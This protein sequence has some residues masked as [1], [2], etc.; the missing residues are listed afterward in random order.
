VVWVI[1][2]TSF[3]L[4]V[5]VILLGPGVTGVREHACQDRID[6]SRITLRQVGFIV[7]SIQNTDPDKQTDVTTG[8]DVIGPPSQIAVPLLRSLHFT[9]MCMSLPLQEQ[10]ANLCHQCHP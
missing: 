1:W 2:C 7:K 5:I 4:L 10:C 3:F 6:Q 8:D 9:L